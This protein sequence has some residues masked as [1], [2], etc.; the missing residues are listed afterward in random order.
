[1]TLG[2]KQTLEKKLGAEITP[3]SDFKDTMYFKFYYTVP[4]RVSQ[5]LVCFCLQNE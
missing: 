4:R 2:E 5:A 3:F 1:L